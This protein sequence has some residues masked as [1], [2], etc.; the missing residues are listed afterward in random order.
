MRYKAGMVFGKP[1][2]ALRRPG[3]RLDNLTVVPASMLPF[4]SQWQTMANSLPQGTTLIILPR[5]DTPQRRILQRVAT[6]LQAK[7]R[8]V[9]ML[10][11][12]DLV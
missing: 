12:E 2:R 11:A 9:A 10:P 4:K 6:R 1:P 5:T 7:G 8:R 3:V